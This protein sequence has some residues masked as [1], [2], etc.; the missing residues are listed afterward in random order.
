MSDDSRDAAVGRAAA[1]AVLAQQAVSMLIALGHSN[2]LATLKAEATAAVPFAVQDDISLDL[3]K[4]A[5]AAQGWIASL[6]MAAQV[7]SALQA[8]SRS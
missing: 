5:D 7:K 8:M 4:V 1:S 6:V 3:D 2:M